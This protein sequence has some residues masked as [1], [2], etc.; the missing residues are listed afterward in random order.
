MKTTSTD[1]M[2]NMRKRNRKRGLVPVEVWV[3]KKAVA[4]IRELAASLRRK[5]KG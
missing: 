1:R 5:L 4:K 2:R 3:P